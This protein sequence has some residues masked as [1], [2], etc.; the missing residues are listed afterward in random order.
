MKKA[1]L[2]IF[3]QFFLITSLFAQG[4]DFALARQ[5]AANGEQQ[6][7]LELYQKLYKEDADTYYPYY[8]TTL[9]ALKKFDE[10]ENATKKMERR[11][12]GDYRYSVALGRIYTQKGDVDKANEI[13][14]G[15][16]KNLPPDPAVIN[17]LASQFYQAENTDYAVKIFLQGRKLLNNDK[18]Y[19]FELIN[20]YRFKRDKAG[21]V[22]EYLSFLPD[23]PTFV[24]QGRRTTIC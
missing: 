24:A 20:L 16:I 22:G 7:A 2:I 13:Y 11:H 21:L 15:L 4:D 5:F 3:L 19:A 9:L 8:V 18:L 23:N 6:K 1:A 17:N 10:A 14:D 12:P